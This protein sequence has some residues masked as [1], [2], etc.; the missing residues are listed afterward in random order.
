M[1]AASS[2]WGEW[3]VAKEKT[4]SELAARAPVDSTLTIQ[5][6]HIICRQRSTHATSS[7]DDNESLLAWKHPVFNK[8]WC[9][10]SG[11]K[12]Q[13]QTQLFVNR[14]SLIKGIQLLY[15]LWRSPWKFIWREGIFNRHEE[16]VDRM[17]HLEHPFLVFVCY[18]RWDSTTH[19]NRN[20]LLN[21]EAVKT[22]HCYD[23]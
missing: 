12:E 17:S 22:H 7:R 5:A 11:A 6:Y 21:T 4:I 13:R 14:L 19:P 20:H 2:L 18:L 16:K 9:R 8:D 23:Q 15:V 10:K 3:P 1:A